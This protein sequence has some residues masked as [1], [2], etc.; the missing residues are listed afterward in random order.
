[1]KQK[2]FPSGT[3]IVYQAL[4]QRKHKDASVFSETPK[5]YYWKLSDL[6]ILYPNFFSI[7]SPIS[8]QTA[9][10][11]KE[12]VL[13]SCVPEFYNLNPE[14]IH[15][16]DTKETFNFYIK[17]TNEIQTVK[18]GKNQ[19]LSAVACEYLFRQI[20]GA[21]FEQ[22]YFLYPNK[23]IEDLQTASQEIKFERIRDQV[24][25]LSNILSAIINRSRGSTKTSFSEVWSLMWTIL[26]KVNSMDELRA[27]FN[28]K[29]SPLD[30]MKQQTLIYMSSVFQDIILHFCNRTNTH[31]QEIKDY[32]STKATLTRAH[33]IRYGST[34]EAQLSEKNSYYRIEKIRRDR[35][36]FWKEQYP[37]SLR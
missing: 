11:I 10:K 33:F 31:I 13:N 23:N 27:N 18:N 9:S 37:L 21:E 36:K 12:C 34:P 1:M 29:S 3:D 6:T 7:K 2:I 5:P 17:A 20:K 28:I 26:Y 19:K 30:Y 24:A 14:P 32:V 22:A 16:L 35:V 8:K 4:N 15:V 25:N